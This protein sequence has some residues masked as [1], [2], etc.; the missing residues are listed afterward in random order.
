MTIRLPVTLAIIH[1]LLTRVAGET[2][3]L[4]ITHVVETMVL[5]P[6]MSRLEDGQE[7]VS[8][9]GETMPVVRLRARL[10]HPART[11]GGG[12]MVV[13]DFSERRSALVVAEFVGQQEIVVKPFDPARGM[14]QL[15]SRSEERR[16]GKEGKRRWAR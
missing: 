1:A 14:P 7:V 4:P 11:N 15:F 12:H 3:A 9:R 10:G 13:L 16:V 8:I 6:E 5:T 2:Y